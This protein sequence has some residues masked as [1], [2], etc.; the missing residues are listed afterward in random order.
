MQDDWWAQLTEEVRAEN[1]AEI[2]AGTVTNLPLNV[3]QVNARGLWEH[4]ES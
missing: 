4:G 2:Q 1:D 3:R